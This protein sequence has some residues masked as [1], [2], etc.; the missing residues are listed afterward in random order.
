MP[1]VRRVV[2]L[3]AMPEESAAFH[4]RVV[5]GRWAGVEAII[6]LAGIGKTAAAAAA[7]HAIVQHAPDALILTGAA[8]ALDRRLRIGDIG[9][10]AGAIDADLDLR[11]WRRELRRGELPFGGGRVMRSDPRLTAAALAAPVDGLFSAYVATGSAFLDTPGKAR[12]IADILPELRDSVDGGE[13]TPDLI[14][15]EGA[16]ILQVAAANRVPALAIRAVSD[17]V[18]GDAVADFTAFIQAAIGRYAVVVEHV[19]AS[20]ATWPAAR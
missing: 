6:A 14:E 17:A 4:A 20:I 7:Q 1:A 3:A 11:A 18:D 12:F 8:G 9:I 19:L 10:V 2:I 16:A 13:R 15:M 5:D